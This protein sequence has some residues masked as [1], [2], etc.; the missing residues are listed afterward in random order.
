MRT[1]LSDVVL[2]SPRDIRKP[3]WLYTRI[4]LCRESAR[5]SVRVVQWWRHSF[6]PSLRFFALFFSTRAPIIKI[7]FSLTC[8]FIL[9]NWKPKSTAPTRRQRRQ[10]RGLREFR[11]WGAD[12]VARRTWDTAA[13]S[14]QRPVPH[15]RPSRL[16][17]ASCA[18][19]RPAAGNGP[20]RGCSRGWSC[21]QLSG[22]RR[23]SRAL[24]TTRTRS[25][26]RG[27]QDA[28]APCR[29]NLARKMKIIWKNLRSKK[30]AVLQ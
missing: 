28:S 30:Q 26:L 29:R 18:S 13:P 9:S 12:L 8:L 16:L 5:R 17:G 6:S 25:R 1:N 23:R 21:S 10:P 3:S 20:S 22:R 2:V 15:W 11:A 19:S 14:R 4:I 24:R 7:D 27:L